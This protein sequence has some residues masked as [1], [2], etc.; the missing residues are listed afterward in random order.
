MKLFCFKLLLLFGLCSAIFAQELPPIVSYTPNV[1]NAENQNWNISQSENKYMYVANNKGLLE[2]TGATWQLYPSPNQTIL[3]SVHTVKNRIY[4]GCYMDFGYWERDAFSTLKY[5]S[6][7]NKIIDK[8]KE[9]EQ[10][11]TILNFREWVLFQSLDSIYIYNTIND[12][13]KIIE[14]DST[15]TKM[16]QIGDQ[17]YFQKI[18]EGLFIIN[19]G[20]AE[21]LS[22][23]EVFK[24]TPISGVFS[25]ENDLLVLTNTSGFFKL[26]NGNLKSWEIPSAKLLENKTIYS[27]IQ[28]KDKSFLLGTI[29]NGMIHIN[30]NGEV[31]YQINQNSGLIN[32]TVLSAFQDIEDNIWLALDNGINCI[33]INSPFRIFEDHKGKIGTTYASAIHKDML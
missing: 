6:L 23:S 7:A 21:L 9:D 2:F 26:N 29:S 19:N 24:T 22:N 1:Y 28:L 3:R 30:K 18:N 20:E 33:N 15:I 27:S 31:L 5:T 12:T 17:I 14:S 10:F 13:F 4:T 25:D 11:W 8:I 16:H 32:N